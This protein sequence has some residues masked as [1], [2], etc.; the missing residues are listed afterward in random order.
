MVKIVD[1]EIAPSKKIRTALTSIFGIG[2]K[3][4]NLL[5]NELGIGKAYTITNIRKRS[6]DKINHILD[7]N[8]ILAFE[9]HKQITRNIKKLMRN[10]SYRGLRHRLHYPVRGQRTKSNASTESKLSKTREVYKQKSIQMSYSNN[11]AKK[12]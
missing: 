1:C 7:K 6:I 4:S 11:K 12:K 9:L 8:H 3:K 2:Y 5:C 10:K